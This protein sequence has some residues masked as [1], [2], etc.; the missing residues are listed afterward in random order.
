MTTKGHITEQI[1][2]SY[3]FDA[4]ELPDGHRAYTKTT[5]TCLLWTNSSEDWLI[6]GICVV[7]DA[8][9]I[10]LN[11]HLELARFMDFEKFI[12]HVKGKD[13]PAKQIMALMEDINKASR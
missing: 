5:W 11:T 3:G 8:A 1:L 10:Q 13:T 6:D 4:I 7:D 2:T 12:S 9:T